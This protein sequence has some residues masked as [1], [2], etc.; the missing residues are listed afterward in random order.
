MFLILIVSV[1][2]V[3][4]RSTSGVSAINNPKQLFDDVAYGQT[5]LRR[6]QQTRVWVTRINQVLRQQAAEIEPHLLDPTSGCDPVTPL[7]VLA[8]ASARSGIDIIYTEQRPPQLPSEIL[9]LGGFVD[10]SSGEVF[11]RL[12][13][14]Y[15]RTA[16]GRTAMALYKHQ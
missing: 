13:R 1:A 6:A 11:D 8:A 3:L 10:P 5:A 14:V 9:W 2:F 4:L 15:K 12:G 7:C 16:K